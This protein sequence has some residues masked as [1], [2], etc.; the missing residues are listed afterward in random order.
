MRT[1]HTLLEQIY[2]CD[3]LPSE[4][5]RPRAPD[6]RPTLNQID[7]EFRLLA[8]RLDDDARSHHERFHQL[9]LDA[10]SMSDYAS[11][12]YGFRHGMLLMQEL[13]KPE[14]N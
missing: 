10:S 1:T 3:F 9:L 11:F 12:A 14:G 5:I 4:N 7:R 13:M 6:Y 2:Y 8:S